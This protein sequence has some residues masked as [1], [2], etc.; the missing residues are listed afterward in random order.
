MILLRNIS[1]E[2]VNGLRDYVTEIQ[3]DCIY[4]YFKS[5]NSVRRLQKMSFTGKYTNVF[6]NI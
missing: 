4:V 6:L 3:Q 1:D 5:I 2:L